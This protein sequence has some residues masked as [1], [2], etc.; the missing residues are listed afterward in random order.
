MKSKDIQNYLAQI[1][2]KGGQ[3]SRRQLDPETA[4]LMGLLRS[5]RNAY[6]KYHAKCFW[7]YDPNLQITIAD[8]RWVGRQLLKHGGMEVAQLGKKLCH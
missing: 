7:S 6:R 3:K 4:R 1:G 5:A 2:R 8:V